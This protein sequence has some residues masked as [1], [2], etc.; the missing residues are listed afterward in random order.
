MTDDGLDSARQRTVEL[1]AALERDDIEGPYGARAMLTHLGRAGELSVMLMTWAQVLAMFGPSADHI[2]AGRAAANQP[3]FPHAIALVDTAITAERE[4]RDSLPAIAAPLK[5]ALADLEDEQIWQLTW[6]MLIEVHAR[7]S[8]TGGLTVL[9]QVRRIHQEACEPGSGEERLAG[10]CAVIIAT[11]MH[12]RLVQAHEALTALLATS[13]T[14][15]AE[16]VSLWLFLAA[17]LMTKPGEVLLQLD[18]T[19][20]PHGLIDPALALDAGVDEQTRRTASVMRV[21]TRAI[22]GIRAGDLGPMEDLARLSE[23]ERMILAWNL[24]GSLALQLRRQQPSGR[25]E[26]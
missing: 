17:T 20:T 16:V 3:W 10:R 5:R 24:A 4:G 26:V 21:A 11:A 12:G 2:F 15:V 23:A 6:A 9:Q 25:Q 1:V 18:A 19:G 22:T 7:T 14:T 8:T 13:R